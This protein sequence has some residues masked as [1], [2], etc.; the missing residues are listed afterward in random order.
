MHCCNG[1]EDKNKYAWGGR[2]SSSAT[3]SSCLILCTVKATCDTCALTERNA[4]RALGMLSPY[5][6]IVGSQVFTCL[7]FIILAYHIKY[8]PLTPQLNIFK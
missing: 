3:C 7:S 4:F 1:G 2:L 5:K 6:S 8:Y